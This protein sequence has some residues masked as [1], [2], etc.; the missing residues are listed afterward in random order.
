PVGCSMQKGKTMKE[1]MLALLVL[2]LPVSLMAGELKLVDLLALPTTQYRITPYLASAQALQRMGK[3][4][5]RALLTA[6]AAKD[7]AF[8]H[9]R[10]IVLCK[11][12]FKPMR[13]AKFRSAGIGEPFFVGK[14]QVADWPLEP[15][16]VVDGVPFYIVR[17]YALAGEAEPMVS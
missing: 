14:T 5:A 1:G 16:A 17:S 10:T 2:L 3:E 9:M 12:L 4:K 11:M 13:E 6:L 15:L 7:E 8:P